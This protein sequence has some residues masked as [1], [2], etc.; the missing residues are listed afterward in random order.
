MNLKNL[1]P[2]TKEKLQKLVD[3]SV[4]L[5]RE[6]ATRTEALKT[7]KAALVREAESHPEA[8]VVTESGG[9]RWTAHGSDGCIARVSFPATGLTAE[10]E[11]Q[12]EIAQKC[13]EIA[14]E[15]FRRLFTTMKSYQLVDDFR[16]QAASILP[17]PKVEALIAILETESA[18]RVSFEAAKRA[19]P[20]NAH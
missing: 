17:A 3:A 19:E 12:G 16:A 11:G 2:M 5:Q 18:P 8:Q 6:I 14:G 7:L 13:H 10:I 15:Q 4:A 1:H 20:A 9:K